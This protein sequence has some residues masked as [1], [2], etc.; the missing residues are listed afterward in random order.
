MHR[1]HVA[2]IAVATSALAGIGW[3]EPIVTFADG[4]G[5]TQGGI[6]LASTVEFG[7]F[8]TFCLETG[9]GITLGTPY[10][11]TISTDIMFKGQGIVDPLNAESAFLYDAFLKGNIPDLLGEPGIDIVDLANAVQLAL[12]IIEEGR[13]T[14]DDN[15]F[16]LVQA[17]EDAV[18]SGQW[19]GL[20]DYRVMNVWDVGH[21]GDP[22]HAKQDVLVLIP[23]SPTL[24]LATLGLLGAVSRRR[25]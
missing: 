18:N 13:P 3:A 10:E 20:G 16:E 1:T 19:S 23:S 4:P 11:Y 12:W 2:T 14:H 8:E 7:D 25:K 9:E 21:V 15:A 17:A 22:A 6:Y 5:T 24:A